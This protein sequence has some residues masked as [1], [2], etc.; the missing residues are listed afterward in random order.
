MICPV[1][2]RARK[3]KVQNPIISLLHIVRIDDIKI[4]DYTDT[5]AVIANLTVDGTSAGNKIIASASDLPKF[6]D[7]KII[8]GGWYTDKT[9]TEPFD[10]DT[11]D[12]ANGRQ[13]NLYAATAGVVYNNTFDENYVS[14][15]YDT[16]DR[17]YEHNDEADAGGYE[18]LTDPDTGNGYIKYYDTDGSHS[19]N[20]PITLYNPSE[21]L[22]N[23]TEFNNGGQYPKEAY[24]TACSIRYEDSVSEDM[25][26]LFKVSFKYNCTWLNAEQEIYMGLRMTHINSWVGNDVND[27]FKTATEFLRISKQTSSDDGVTG[28]TDAEAYCVLKVPGSLRNG[29]FGVS[30]YLNGQV[31]VLLDDVVVEDYTDTNYSLVNTYIDVNLDSQTITPLTEFAPPSR[32]DCNW[33]K[34]EDCTIEWTNYT[35]DRASGSTE[36]LSVNI[37]GKTFCVHKDDDKDNACDLCGAYMGVHADNDKD[38]ICD[39]G[40]SEVIGEHK[41]D[42]KDHACDYGCSETFGEHKDANK[43]HAC[44]YGCTEKIGEHKDADKDHVCDYGCAVAIGAHEDKTNDHKCDYCGEEITTC[45]DED[46]DH[47]CDICGATLSKHNLEKVSAKDATVTETGNKEHW[48]C[49]VCGKYFADE[50][51]ANEVKLDDIVISKLP[52][53]IIEGKEQ[54]LTAGE[55]K[56]LTFRSNAAFG[57]FIRVELDGKTVDPKNYTVKE[58]SII[59]TLNADYVETL[60][61][62]KHTLGIVSTSGTA[63][64]AFTVDE[65]PADNN[66]KPANDNEGTQGN[67]TTSPQTGDNNMFW[68]WVALLLASAIGIAG[69]A[70]YS[71]RKTTE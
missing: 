38:H 25:V 28:W 56:E 22:R 39:Y 9:M 53:E 31:T 48:I 66:D 2:T 11:Y 36:N 58:G 59:V 61:A 71:K 21:A 26:K 50:N 27:C 45:L 33:Y 12:I 51:G 20:R 62:G 10:F 7:Q 70:V 35:A 46:K 68:L 41:D 37:Y 15:F 8:P 52:P 40:C 14:F 44:D 18:Y 57:D 4:E 69:V 64:I 42:N 60:P 49:K 54:S 5:N 30:L 34:D 65:K 17:V 47:L 63:D 29:Q 19:Y 43:D 6:V 23:Y 1:N 3:D 16:D 55:K 32:E 13:I 24:R 67:D